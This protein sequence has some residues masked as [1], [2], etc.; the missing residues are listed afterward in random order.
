MS[1]PR[2]PDP[3]GKLK[4]RAGV[5]QLVGGGGRPLPRSH[6]AGG[7]GAF[8]RARAG[9][10][11]PSGLGSLRFRA[12]SGDTPSDVGRSV[13]ERNPV[14][15]R[16]EAAGSDMAKRLTNAFVKTAPPGRHY[17]EHGLMLR[18][19]PTGAKNW[20]W[21]GTVLGRRVDLGLGAYPYTS[22]A[23]ARR[24]AFENRRLARAGG[25]PW[26]AVAESPAPTFEQALEEVLAIQRV[27]WRPGGRSEAQWRASLR[28]YAFPRLGRMRVDHI[29]TRDVMAVLLPIWGTRLENRAPCA[30]EDRGG[31]EVGGGERLSGRQPRRRR[32][33]GRVAAGR[34]AREALPGP[35]TRTG[36]RSHREGAGLRRR[37]RG[38]AGDRVPGPDG[39]PV[40]RGARWEEVDTG[41]ATWTIPGERTKSGRTHR[42]PLSSAAV[43]VLDEAREVA[44]GSGLV[45]PST[46][47]A[48]MSSTT[49]AKVLRDQ[50]DRLRA[51][52]VPDQLPGLVRRHRRR[53]RGGRGRIGPCGAEQGRGCIR[54]GDAV[55]AAPRRHGSLERLCG[56]GMDRRALIRQRQQLDEEERVLEGLDRKLVQVYEVDR[57]GSFDEFRKW[58][59]EAAARRTAAW[60]TS[61]ETPTL[62]L[63]LIAPPPRAAGFSE[64]SGVHGTPWSGSGPAGTG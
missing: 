22:L 49:L 6:G 31:D 36:P 44:D 3:G 32:G 56:R 27:S 29:T 21:R 63:V 26:A 37:N 62:G 5:P 42:V 47:G 64:P 60:A 41:S 59:A 11:R 7:C 10:R 54:P 18:V 46:T 17:D 35:A 40:R 28:T 13:G 14:F 51:A 9:L 48:V 12:V 25:D 55:R 15:H 50:G 8:R 30:P 61:A 57:H 53:A 19:W 16:A 45:F 33:R 38:Q 4:S 2:G 43:G 23:E 39:G 52:R 20:I 24:K 1:V 34:R 58:D